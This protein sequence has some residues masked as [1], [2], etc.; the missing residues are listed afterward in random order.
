[1][2]LHKVLHHLA[3]VKAD[4]MDADVKVVDVITTYQDF[5]NVALG[6]KIVGMDKICHLARK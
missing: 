2:N 1:M 3:S 6:K 4:M 5:N